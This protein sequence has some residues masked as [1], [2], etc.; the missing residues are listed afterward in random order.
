MRIRRPVIAVLVLVA[1]ALGAWEGGRGFLAV[2][3]WR[4]A[5]ERLER[6]GGDRYFIPAVQRLYSPGGKQAP[7]PTD[8]AAWAT[9]RYHGRFPAEEVY[10]LAWLPTQELVLLLG[11][12]PWEDSP[13]RLVVL[14][15]Q[16]SETLTAEFSGCD[17]HARGFD[18]QSFAAWDGPV[19]LLHHW[20]TGDCALLLRLQEQTLTVLRCTGS[21]EVE[22]YFLGWCNLHLVD[23][24]G[25]GIP[26]VQGCIGKDAICPTCGREAEF[27]LV[28]W[29]WVDGS[30]RKWTERGGDCG[31]GCE[32][33]WSN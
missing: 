21:R 3:L 10:D 2:L 9:R 20:G 23:V 19:L 32:L 15:L 27:N 17:L 6:W 26:E 18:L 11:T 28:T 31:L 14:D 33:A 12:P 22:P 8:L 30:Y 16:H 24:D 29:R 4:G 25:D 13:T 7:C 5:Y 1:L